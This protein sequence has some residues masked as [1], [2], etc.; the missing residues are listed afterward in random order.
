M[1]TRQQL[2]Y[3]LEQTLSQD[4]AELKRLRLI[5]LVP[6]FLRNLFR[7]AALVVFFSIFMGFFRVF[8]AEFRGTGSGD[9]FIWIALGIFSLAGGVILFS[10][11]NR[12]IN[13]SLV[14]YFPGLRH[15][16]GKSTLIVVGICV[17]VAAAWQVNLWLFVDSVMEARF[18]YRFMLV[19]GGVLGLVLVGSLFG[20]PSQKYPHRYKREIVPKVV[21]YIAPG[22]T[23]SPEG[24]VSQ[25][26]FEK[27]RMFKAD[28]IVRY[29]GAHLIKYPA[30]EP[31]RQLSWL[32]V[33]NKEDDRV[34]G[35]RQIRVSEVFKGIF[36]VV[37]LKA[38]SAA[39]RL[40]SKKTETR[41]GQRFTEQTHQV[42]TEDGWEVRKSGREEFDE[43]YTWSMPSKAI[44]VR[45]TAQFLTLLGYAEA[46]CNGRVEASIQGDHLYMAFADFSSYF[47]P[48]WIGSVMDSDDLE[49]F[50]NFWETLQGVNAVFEERK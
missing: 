14:R 30:H 44:P 23:Y 31:V 40:E 9:V 35:K 25:T 6:Q 20:L 39:M 11:I 47:E 16:I 38:P 22:S 8:F 33:R 1:K 3:F 28:D 43:K 45:F 29:R 46:W 27:S 5:L 13:T 32:Q 49:N 24:M 21:R 2:S 10:I 12:A 4:L 48:S 7:L 15:A 50:Q 42:V 36:L 41:L 26:Y 18:I 34:R 19:A 17:L 37:R